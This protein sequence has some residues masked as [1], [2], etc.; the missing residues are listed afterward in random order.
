MRCFRWLAV[1]LMV[2]MLVAGC[3][4]AL[5]RSGRFPSCRVGDGDG[6]DGN[7]S[8]DSST[9]SCVEG[10]SPET[11]AHRAFAFDGTIVRIGPATTN[12]AGATTIPLVA[13]TFDVNRWFNG[14]SGSTVTVDVT[15]PSSGAIGSTEEQAPERAG[16]AAPVGQRRASLGWPAPEGPDR[17][18][19]RVHPDL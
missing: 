12:R 7:S 8:S 19:L 1:S 16:G 11:L 5:S 9:A 18:G 4:A 6:I 13:A 14:G 10:Y 3:S 15:A 17:V 2:P